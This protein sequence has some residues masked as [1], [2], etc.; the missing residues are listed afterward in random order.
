MKTKII[1]LSIL[2]ICFFAS[3][4]K[5][6]DIVFN[7]SG[8]PI[9]L[10]LSVKWASCNLGANSPEQ[11]GHWIAW[12]EVMP[13]SHYHY[14]WGNYQYGEAQPTVLPASCD[15]ASV[16]WGGTWR[17][18]T[19]AEWLELI[20]N[21]TWTWTTRNKREGY[22]VQGSNG[23][24][25]FLPTAGRLTDLHSY[26]GT[27][28]EYWSSSLKTDNPAF[29]QCVCFGENIGVRWS[30]CWRYVGLSVRPVLIEFAP[31]VVNTTS[32]TRIT[33]VNAVAVG[34]VI[35]DSNA[36]VTDRGICVGTLSNPTAADTKISAGCGTGSFTC[37]LTNLQPN[38]TYY[39]RAYAV[40]SQGTSYGEEITFT[41]LKTG[42]AVDLCLSVKWASCNVGANNPEDYGSYFAW[43]EI[44]SKDYYDW[45][46]YSYVDGPYKNIIK[47][48][49]KSGFGIVDNKTTLELSDDAAYANWGSAWRMPTDAELTELR[50]NCT[51]TWTTQN[52]VNGYKVTSKSNGN[53]IFLPAAGYRYASSLNCVGSN[54]EYWSSSLITDQPYYAYCIFFL[55][56]GDVYWGRGA[57]AVGKSVRPVCQ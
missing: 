23:N 36:S 29:A 56:D 57:R 6:G 41:T 55:S 28:G 45:S 13:K 3:C 37:D 30:V 7:P 53:F 20:N 52:G 42:D 21:C 5:D 47:Y 1:V 50:T 8:V 49:N 4:E 31:P 26:S 34:D 32:V 24:S 22:E 19:D 51:W 16:N 12:G 17:I 2:I 44:E 15:A 14:T 46:N 48:S 33:A 54:G 27:Y 39:I 43:G 38:T 18:P 25:I 10:G 40:N 9:D 11:K 35:S